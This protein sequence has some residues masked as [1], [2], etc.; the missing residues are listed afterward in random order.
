MII[1]NKDHSLSLD[2]MQQRIQ[3]EA[4]GISLGAGLV[5]GNAYEVLDG[6][7]VISFEPEIAHLIMVMAAVYML[8]LILGNRKYA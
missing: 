3:P 4:M 5:I 6:I 7:R 8:S 2:E 1:A